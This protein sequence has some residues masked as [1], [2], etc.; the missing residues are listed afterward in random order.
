MPTRYGSATVWSVGRDLGH[1]HTAPVLMYKIET[2]VESVGW[3]DDPS[4]LGWGCVDSDNRWPTMAAANAAM[5]ELCNGWGCHASD[6]RVVPAA[7]IPFR[8]FC[9]TTTLGS[10]TVM[11][12]TLAGAITAGL[13]L[14]GRGSELKS[15]FQVGDW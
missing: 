10:V 11:A 15:C 1:H 9:V 5:E 4:R 3:T 8:S 7:P 2:Y 13:E 12:T 6:L 14:S